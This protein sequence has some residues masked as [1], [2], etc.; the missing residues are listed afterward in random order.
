M[1]WFIQLKVH[2]KNKAWHS[3][4]QGSANQGW[5]PELICGLIKAPLQISIIVTIFLSL[6]PLHLNIR[7]WLGSGWPT[8]SLM[9]DFGG[10]G[11]GT[12][13]GSS[14]TKLACSNEGEQLQN[15]T[16]GMD[17][18]Y[19]KRETKPWS[20]KSHLLPDFSSA[21][22]FF[23]FLC[24]LHLW[25]MEVLGPE[26]KWLQQRWILNLLCQAGD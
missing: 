9:L 25:L 18:Q 26:I 20:N 4:N 6:C 16:E 3:K 14:L 23:F 17:A 21:F 8:L 19:S 10:A 1:R 12:S 13:I 22:F 2:L 11:V 5:W 15:E 24:R 7:S